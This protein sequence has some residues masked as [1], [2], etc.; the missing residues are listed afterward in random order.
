MVNSPELVGLLGI[1]ARLPW[2]WGMNWL[3][4][5]QLNAVPPGKG[6]FVF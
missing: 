4:S 2:S 5:L 6:S 3:Q 1:Q